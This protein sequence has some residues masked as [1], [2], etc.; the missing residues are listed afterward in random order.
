MAHQ[1]MIYNQVSLSNQAMCLSSIKKP[2]NMVVFSVL[3]KK[4]VLFL[5][6]IFNY[7]AFTVVRPHIRLKTLFPDMLVLLKLKWDKD[8]LDKG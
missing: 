7:Q 5:V 8:S 4:L 1:K 3:D 6:Y 2:A